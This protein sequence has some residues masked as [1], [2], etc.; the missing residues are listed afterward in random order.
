MTSQIRHENNYVTR[1]KKRNYKISLENFHEIPEYVLKSEGIKEET[2]NEHLAQLKKL[3][4]DKAR[5][6]SELGIGHVVK[7]WL[8][9]TRQRIENEEMGK[10]VKGGPAANVQSTVSKL[11]NVEREEEAL[12]AEQ[13]SGFVETELSE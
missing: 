3:E 13:A 11:G 7:L 4:N 1:T 2:E 5:E 12:K 6:E 9:P 10:I 8:L